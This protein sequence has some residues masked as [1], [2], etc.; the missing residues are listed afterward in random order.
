MVSNLSRESLLPYKNKKDFSKNFTEK[1]L[2]FK[3]P[4]ELNT[5]KLHVSFNSAFNSIKKCLKKV[6]KRA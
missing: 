4:Y 2:F 1:T 3:F 6:P 5:S